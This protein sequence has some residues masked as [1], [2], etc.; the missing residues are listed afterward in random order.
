MSQDWEE[1][2]YT[3]NVF[4]EATGIIP[5]HATPEVPNAPCMAYKK[6]RNLMI[7]IGGTEVKMLFNHI[8]NITETDTWPRT[9][10]KISNRIKE[11]TNKQ[12]QGS[13]GYKDYHNG[14][15]NDICTLE[16]AR[17][18]TWTRYDMDT[19]ARD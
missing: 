4:L 8:G 10:E 11:Q 1:Y 6:M 12:Q 13:H 16:I 14:L 7:L 15:Q 2:V 5:A 9:L 19:V 17:Q 3:F 18:H